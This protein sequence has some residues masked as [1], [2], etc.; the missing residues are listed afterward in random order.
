MT[1]KEK[2]RELYKKFSKNCIDSQNVPK[3]IIVCID[4][5]ISALGSDRIIYGSEYRFEEDIFWSEVKHEI[6][7]L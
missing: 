2:A 6:E 4:E 1:P 3:N 5:I 7:K